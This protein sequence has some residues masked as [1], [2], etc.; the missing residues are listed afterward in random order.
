MQKKSYVTGLAI[1]LMLSLCFALLTGCGS[2]GTPSGATDPVATASGEAATPKPSKAAP[3]I[4]TDG[5][6]G[7]VCNLISFNETKGI[8]VQVLGVTR[9]DGAG[10]AKPAAG[11]EF[12]VVEF[13]VKASTHSH[14]FLPHYFMLEKSTNIRIPVSRGAT[15]D[16][17]AG[18]E[19]LKNQE[20]AEGAV[21]TGKLVFE[22]TKGETDL[23]FVYEDNG[24]LAGRYIK[25]N[26]NEELPSFT[27]IS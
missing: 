3:I 14:Q 15:Y 19:Q 17:V 20:I 2:S 23:F 12:V 8:E 21:L 10:E 26:L 7:T 18:G 5:M 9:S 25:I 16:P 24:I 27:P 11:N 6:I 22:V 13:S 4:V 1:V